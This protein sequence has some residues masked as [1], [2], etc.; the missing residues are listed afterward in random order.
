MPGCHR[1]DIE[2]SACTAETCEDMPQGFTD[3]HGKTHERSFVDRRQVARALGLDPYWHQS[4]A[5]R[6]RLSSRGV[7][8]T[9]ADRSAEKADLEAELD[10]EPSGEEDTSDQDRNGADQTEVIN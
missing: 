10:S 9:P 7:Q 5:R 2:L 4:Q 8:K 6:S 3:V 1:L